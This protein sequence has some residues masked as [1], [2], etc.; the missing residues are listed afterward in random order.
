MSCRVSSLPTPVLVFARPMPQLVPSP[1]RRIHPG[2]VELIFPFSNQYCQRGANISVV[3]SIIVI[4]DRSR[5]LRIPTL[6]AGPALIVV[7]LWVICCGL[8]AHPSRRG[9]VLVVRWFVWQVGP[10][11]SL[12]ST[13]FSWRGRSLCRRWEHSGQWGGM[14]GEIRERRTMM[15]VV[16]RFSLRTVRASK[17]MGSPSCISFPNPFIERT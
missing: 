7:D 15:K 4:F 10:Q 9:G 2:I 1:L 13:W 8:G 11:T 3:Q 14:G 16:V 6:L 12:H 17:Y 5:P